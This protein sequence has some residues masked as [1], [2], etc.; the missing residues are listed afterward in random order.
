MTTFLAHGKETS[1]LL[2]FSTNSLNIIGK[3][4]SATTNSPCDFYSSSAGKKCVASWEH[5]H[6]P[7]EL[8][9]CD[10]AE[11]HWTT[12]GIKTLTSEC[13][14]AHNAAGSNLLTNLEQRSSFFFT[15]TA[16]EAHHCWHRSL[17]LRLKSEQQR[18]SV[19]LCYLR[20]QQCCIRPGFFTAAQMLLQNMEHKLVWALETCRALW[21][22]ET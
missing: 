7:V 3:V 6:L 2:I 17:A 18:A 14:S 10:A 15:C 8:L 22:G 16:S 5:P 13:H 19:H 12:V 1:A 20:F 4:P 9:H 11:R 21:S